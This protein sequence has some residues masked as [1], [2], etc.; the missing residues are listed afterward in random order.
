MCKCKRFFQIITPFCSDI[1]TFVLKNEH[2]M[3]KKAPLPISKRTS[4]R[5]H[6]QTFA[7]NDEEQRALKRYISKYNVQ[8]KSK[9]MRET[10]MRAIISRFEEDHPT[11]F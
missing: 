7:L 1:I 10:L 8:N 9:F 2:Y 11:L 4:R 6:R 5:T 3:A